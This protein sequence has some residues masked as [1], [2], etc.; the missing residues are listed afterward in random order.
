MAEP[1]TKAGA[2]QVLLQL[3]PET[4]REINDEAI[5]GLL[6]QEMITQVFEQAWKHQFE[7]DRGQF[8]RV[9]RDMVLEAIE[10]LKSGGSVQ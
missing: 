6:G 10:Q 8:Q 2:L 5:R 4:S 7:D 1:R 3:L 9:T